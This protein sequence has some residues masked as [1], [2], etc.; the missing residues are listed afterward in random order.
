[1]TN[2]KKYLYYA[3][4]IFFTI[5]AIIG[6]ILPVIPTTPFLLL[7]IYFLNEVSP[8]LHAKILKIPIFG[9]ALRD[10]D[11]DRVI[12]P[13]AKA[14]A[15]LLLATSGGY[16]W[17]FREQIPIYAKVTMTITLVIIGVFILRQKS[18]V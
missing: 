1:M 18:K 15:I 17:Y 10:W 16:I 4:G 12:R 6:A 13:K 3:L 8:A 9:K 5:C 2:F 7:A 14:E 11:E